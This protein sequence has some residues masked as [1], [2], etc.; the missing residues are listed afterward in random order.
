MFHRLMNN[1]VFGAEQNI[2]K[3]L[4]IW[5]SPAL[6]ILCWV[7][8]FPQCCVLKCSKCCNSLC[9]ML[10]VGENVVAQRCVV[11]VCLINT[12]DY[13]KKCHVLV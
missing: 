10:N 8:I 3:H 9:D 2:P 7:K 6:L 12:I 4:T 1:A 5:I 11:Q 13:V